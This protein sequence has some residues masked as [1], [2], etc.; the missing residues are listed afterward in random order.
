MTP[1]ELS[2]LIEDD[3]ARAGTGF[4]WPG[5]PINQCLQKPEKRRFLNSRS[6]DAPEDFWLVF[7]EGPGPGEGYMV[8]YDEELQ[9]FGLAVQGTADP[10][11]IGFYG[12]FVETLNS[13]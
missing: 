8:V 1:Q 2:C 13:M 10:V 3:L 5:R 12:G 6:D 9:E 4:A 11:V 7:E